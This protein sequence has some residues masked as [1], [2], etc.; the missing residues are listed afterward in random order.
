M[1][2]HEHIDDLSSEL[3]S[4]ALA[5]SMVRATSRYLADRELGDEDKKAIRRSKRLFVALSSPD[6]GLPKAGGRLRQLTTRDGAVDALAAAGAQAESEDAQAHLKSLARA[7]DRILK[8]DRTEDVLRDAENIQRLYRQVGRL[9]LAR[10]S[11]RLHARQDRFSWLRLTSKGTSH[12][13]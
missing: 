6:A 4:S 11:S 8:G 10:S 13:S 12:S 2:A 1:P 3:S 5:Q 7:L 9:T